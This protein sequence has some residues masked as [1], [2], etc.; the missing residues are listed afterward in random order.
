MIQHNWWAQ[1]LPR[2]RNQ[3][4]IVGEKMQKYGI[5][6]VLSYSEINDNIP[7]VFCMIFEM[8]IIFSNRS[9]R[10]LILGAYGKNGK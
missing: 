10:W 5:R 7:N 8:G 3:F 2:L 4:N 9:R 6:F 1:S